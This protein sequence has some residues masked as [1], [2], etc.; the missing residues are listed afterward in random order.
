MCY[1]MQRKNVTIIMQR[2]NMDIGTASVSSSRTKAS[3]LTLD[4]C[5]GGESGICFLL[6]KKPKDTKE[7]LETSEKFQ[8]HIETIVQDIEYVLSRFEDEPETAW[9]L[10]GFTIGKQRHSTTP[11]QRCAAVPHFFL[12]FIFYVL[13]DTTA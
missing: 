9:K 6:E 4:D 3:V 10:L 12:M 1:V 11:Q 5:I 7:L 2:R 13:C 8:K